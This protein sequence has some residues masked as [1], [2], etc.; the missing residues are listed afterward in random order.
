MES[1]LEFNELSTDNR[2]FEE[3]KMGIRKKKAS[4]KI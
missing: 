3:A 1:E 2:E 4:K